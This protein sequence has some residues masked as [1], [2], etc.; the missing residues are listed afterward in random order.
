MLCSLALIFLHVSS[1][2]ICMLHLRNSDWDVQKCV[3]KLV[4]RQ[5]RAHACD[6]ARRIW[7]QWLC[8]YRPKDSPD[9]V[10]RVQVIKQAG[11]H[12]STIMRAPLLSITCQLQVFFPSVV[13]LT[14]QPTSPGL[15]PSKRS[16]SPPSLACGEHFLLDT[17]NRNNHL[18]QT[19]REPS[20]FSTNE[21]FLTLSNKTEAFKTE[22]WWYAVVERC[23]MWWKDQGFFLDIIPSLY[24]QHLRKQNWVVFF[25]P[26]ARR[27][28][29]ESTDE[30]VR[31]RYR[32]YHNERTSSVFSASVWKPHT[33]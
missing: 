8:I 16:S 10:G 5:I 21:L 30:S 14:Q 31:A 20:D 12:R 25:Q 2:N 11:S 6:H 33:L 9:D 32:W 7:S 18:G 1:G 29:I 28:W 27:G 23:E 26:S 19:S 3:I 4:R 13:L 17:S 22:P 24:I 15:H